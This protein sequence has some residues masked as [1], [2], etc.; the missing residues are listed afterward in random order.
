AAIEPE[1]TS[2]ISRPSARSA[3]IWRAQSASAA[4][5]RPAPLLVTSALPILTTRRRAFLMR[6]L[7]M[8]GVV[9]GRAR[10]SA[11][12]GFVVV[13]FAVFVF[14]QG[15]GRVGKTR[16]FLVAL[17]EREFGGGAGGR[18]GGEAFLFRGLARGAFGFDAIAFGVEIVLHR[19][20]DLAT[21]FA[22]DR[23]DLEVALHRAVGREEGGDALGAL[24]L[25][26][27]VE[28]V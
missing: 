10:R 13:E 7:M 25:G 2:R 28:L 26:D 24:L 15:V 4:L 9:G 20:H 12:A 3:A 8:A 19:E 6:F 21:A 17:A 14:G 11:A 1:E 5:S 16:R 23:R 27:E 18:C 22:V